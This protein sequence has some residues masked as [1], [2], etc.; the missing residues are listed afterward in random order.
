MYILGINT[1]FHD[2]S[3]CIIQDGQLLAAVE[4]ERSV[5]RLIDWTRDNHY[6]IVQS[7]VCNL[8]KIDTTVT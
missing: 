4:E 1:V 2:S 6:S 5:I 8:L 3:A 7:A